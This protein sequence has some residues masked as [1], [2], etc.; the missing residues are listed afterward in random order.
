MWDSGDD[1]S[2]IKKVSSLRDGNGGFIW[3]ETE[4]QRL[5]LPEGN[6]LIEK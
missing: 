3:K 1:G 2:C 4:H 5:Q 6:T